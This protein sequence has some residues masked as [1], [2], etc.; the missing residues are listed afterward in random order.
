ML[1]SSTFYVDISNIYYYYYLSVTIVLS[2]PV[3]TSNF[4]THFHYFQSE[5]YFPLH[6]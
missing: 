6:E 2:V 4:G 5:F 1:L 3:F